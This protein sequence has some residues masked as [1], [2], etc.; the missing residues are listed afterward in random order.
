MKASHKLSKTTL[1]YMALRALFLQAS[2]NFGRMQN[3]GFLFTVIPGLRR[4]YRGQE[5]QRECRRHLAYFNSNPVMALPIIGASL[6]LEE[7]MSHG[8]DPTMEVEEFK[9]LLAGPC[10]AMGDSFF[11]GTLRPLAATIA[12][13]LAL[14][15]TLWSV[16]LFMLLYNVPAIG[17]RFF[18]FWQG[19]AADYKII[20]KL[21][22]WH[23]SDLAYRLRAL[24][25]V[26]LGG[27]SAWVVFKGFGSLQ[28]SG[29]WGW[30]VVPGVLLA[31]AF[32]RRGLSALGMLVGLVALLWI[33][34]HVCNSVRL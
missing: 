10:A 24:L 31:G 13:W 14:A 22:H 7:Q 2:W 27:L 19:Y 21:Q 17:L 26:I 20:E 29:M 3:L 4:L 23:L 12:V 8:Q 5:L 33:G 16:A 6:R 30:L 9:T 28:L 11:W 32:V 25:I 15:G 34:L 18:G 1:W